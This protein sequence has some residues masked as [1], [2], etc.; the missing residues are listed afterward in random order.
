VQ[1]GYALLRTTGWYFEAGWTPGRYETPP[2]EWA[3]QHGFEN[4]EHHEWRYWLPQSEQERAASK[5]EMAR[6][7]SQGCQ[8]A[9][10]PEHRIIKMQDESGEEGSVQVLTEEHL[11]IAQKLS[12]DQI[13]VSQLSPDLSRI[14]YVR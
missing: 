4:A 2:T 14:D 8:K 13:A 12:I 11:L 6:L 1:A 7:A 3:M 10:M 9:K 5:I